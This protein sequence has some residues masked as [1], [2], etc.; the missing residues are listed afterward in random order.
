MLK[1]AE[2]RVL[3]FG[4][5]EISLNPGECLVVAGPSGSGKSVLLRALADLNISSGTVMLDDVAR[6]I[7]SGPEWRRMVRYLSA[8]PGW[9]AETPKEHFK[10]PDRIAASFA[11]LDLAPELAI[12]P[13]SELSTGERQRVAL[14]RALED[15]PVLLLADEPTAALDDVSIKKSEKLLRQ[16]LKAGGMLILVTHSS[17]QAKAFGTSQLKLG[18]KSDGGSGS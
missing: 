3:D 8:E 9:W 7:V 6:E 12:R 18:R 5:Y 11:L 4:P 17:K 13:V 15:N 1:V 10:H 16:Y 14:L 2:L